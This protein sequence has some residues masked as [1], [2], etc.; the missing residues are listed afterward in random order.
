MSHFASRGRRTW[1]PG[2]RATGSLP[3]A[4]RREAHRLAVTTFSLCCLAGSASGKNGCRRALQ[5]GPEGEYQWDLRA[6][7][8]GFWFWGGFR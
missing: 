3:S 7:G 5:Q 6:E 2:K 4:L 1:A 8:Q